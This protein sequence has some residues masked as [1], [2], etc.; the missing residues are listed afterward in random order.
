MNPD[1]TRSVGF[2]HGYS[3]C[4]PF[5]ERLL[6]GDVKAAEL[7]AVPPAATAI[8]PL[9]ARLGPRRSAS[10]CCLPYSVHRLLLLRSLPQ[11][12]HP[13]RPAKGAIADSHVPYPTPNA[14]GVNVTSMVQLASGLR[15]LPQVLVCAAAHA[16]A[17]LSEDPGLLRARRARYQADVEAPSLAYS[18]F[19]CLRTGMS[20]SAYFQRAKKSW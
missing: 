19:A 2:T 6:R 20:G 3:P 13:V 11:Q 4:F 17:S 10:R 16:L 1:S 9:L 15:L 14:V 7:M 5:G 18:A 8:F 12:T